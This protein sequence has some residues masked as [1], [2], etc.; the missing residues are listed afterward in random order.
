MPAE[1]PSAQPDP[2]DAPPK[3]FDR[4]RRQAESVVEDQKRVS[5]VVR[6]AYE[7]L[8][9]QSEHLGGLRDDLPLLLRL[10]RAWSKG[11]YTRVPIK[12][13]V[14][15]LAAVLYFVNP[16]DL[17]PDFLPVV[18]YLDDAAVVGYVLRVLKGELDRFAEWEARQRA[19]T[20]FRPR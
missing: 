16:L 14:T 5:H 1:K 2:A 20:P 10:V 6:Q 19:A 3:G 7:K 8:T 12:A 9:A 17:I 15:V 13:V 11:S 18:G 4:H